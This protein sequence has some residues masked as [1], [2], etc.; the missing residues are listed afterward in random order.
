MLVLRT[1]SIVK[2]RW[3]WLLSWFLIIRIASV[4]H[5]PEF[6]QQ[7]KHLYLGDNSD[8]QVGG[9]LFAQVVAECL[10]VLDKIM[11]A[12]LLLFKVN[13]DLVYVFLLLFVLFARVCSDHSVHYCED[14]PTP[15]QT[16][17]QRDGLHHTAACQGYLVGRGE[18]GGRM[19]A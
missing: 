2:G 13:L 18:A 15:V 3:L 14:G 6:F 1:V 19:L 7:I 12:G 4:D 16:H 10:H 5:F 11:A 9:V 17:T 8:I